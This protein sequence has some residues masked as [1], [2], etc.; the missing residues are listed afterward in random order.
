[1]RRIYSAFSIFMLFAMLCSAFSFGFADSLSAQEK[2]P[3]S[4]GFV[5]GQWR[6]MALQTIVG[7]EVAD[8]GLVKPD[9][10][11][12]AVVIADVTN[13]GVT[14][15]FN[16]S[17]L[18]LGSTTGGPLDMT[19]GIPASNTDSVSATQAL[20]LP[21]ISDE[22]VFTV[23]E[24][25]TIRMAVVF[26]L[27]AVAAEGAD[28]VLRLDDQVMSISNTVLDSLAIA[29]LPAMVPQMELQVADIVEV[30]GNSQ[31]SVSLRAGGTETVTLAGVQTPAFS[32]NLME[33]CFAGESSN[34]VLSLAGGTVWLESVPGSDAKLFWYNDP[35]TQTFGLLNS[36]LIKQGFAG[37][38]DAATPYASWF[39]SIE[40][41]V[42]GQ[43]SGLWGVCKNAQGAWINPP[44]PTPVPTP[45]A[46]QVRSEY[47]WVDVRDLLIRPGVFEGDKIAVS[48][49]VFNI[50][51]EGEVTFIQI[52]VDGGDYD[53]VS[54]VFYGDSRGIYEDS[55]IT[56]YGVGAGT[57]EGT[58][59]MGGTISQPLIEADMI[60]H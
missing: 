42:E 51:V 60:D 9:Q 13:T 58:N 21:G 2:E 55:W 1:M 23:P 32:S 43:Q 33:G 8:A 52:Y 22:G 59:M 28:L 34:A 16:P 11:V 48:G 7:E 26:Q 44:T 20:Q 57:F 46:E 37:T 49:S 50:M 27:P 12:S 38:S 10:G 19:D 36:Q 25:G 4:A 5:S 56:I 17:A 3:T 39:G 15:T 29:A 6:I 30:P 53:A 31:V 18:Q 54:V 41:F 40:T 45:S 47:E 35:S 14:G 24:N